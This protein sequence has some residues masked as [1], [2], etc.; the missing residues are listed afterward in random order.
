MKFLDSLEIEDLNII[1]AHIEVGKKFMMT[2]LITDMRIQK[3]IFKIISNYL[4]QK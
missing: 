4:L 2:K 1:F 3:K